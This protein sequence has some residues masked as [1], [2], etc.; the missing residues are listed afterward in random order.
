[1]YQSRNIQGYTVREGGT[2]WKHWKCERGCWIRGVYEKAAVR[3]E[4]TVLAPPP[5]VDL[6][7]LT[8]SW[9]AQWAENGQGNKRKKLQILFFLSC[10][11]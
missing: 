2:R 5:K 4:S 8:E 3:S 1:V 11:W 9:K 6:T 7:A 10:F